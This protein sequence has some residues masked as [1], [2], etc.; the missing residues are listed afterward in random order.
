MSYQ[1]V[2]TTKAERDADVMMSWI[3]QYAPEK[4]ALW[5]LDFRQAAASLSDFPAR[6]PLALENR[7]G[8]EIRQLLFGKYRLLFLIEGATVWV[9]HVRHQKQKPLLPSEL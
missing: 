7:V 5:Y 3:A 9:L 8:Q 6:C 2:I 1:V 4:A